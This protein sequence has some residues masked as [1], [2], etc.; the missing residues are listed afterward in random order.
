MQPHEH[1]ALIQAGIPSIPSI[2][3]TTAAAVWADLG[4]GWGAF[5][6]ALRELLGDT[7]T[8]YAL[9][10]DA[11]AFVH[12]RKA[13][14]AVSPRGVLHCVHADITHPLDLP[15]LDGVLMANALHFIEDQAAVLQNIRRALKPEGRLL[16]VEYDVTTPRPWIPY[17]VPPAHFLTLA[18]AAGFTSAQRIAERRSPSSGI[19]MYAALAHH[20]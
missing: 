13:H 20:L 19:V 12:L 1:R 11:P 5:T 18:H 14:T 8:L 16:L 15:P 4:A 6:V 2:P 7:A 9:D 3:A 10:N 17:P